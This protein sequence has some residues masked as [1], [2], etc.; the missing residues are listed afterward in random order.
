MFAPGKEI[1]LLLER[2]SRVRLEEGMRM[3]LVGTWKFEKLQIHC[4]IRR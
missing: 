3:T 4:K 1:A 2:V